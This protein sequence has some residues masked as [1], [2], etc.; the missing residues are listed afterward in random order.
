MMVVALKRITLVA[1]CP[2]M[3][4][5]APVA[6]PAP[7]IVTAVPP[8]VEP[9]EGEIDEAMGGKVRVATCVRPPTALTSID[10]VP[11]SPAGMTTLLKLVV[12]SRV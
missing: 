2:P 9:D 8:D 5:V 7:V 1:G 11:D 6:N 10:T 12:S 4:T 3:V